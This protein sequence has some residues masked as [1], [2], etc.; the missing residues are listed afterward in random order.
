L[1]QEIKVNLR[2]WKR[3]LISRRSYKLFPRIHGHTISIIRFKY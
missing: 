3:I 1:N 2:W